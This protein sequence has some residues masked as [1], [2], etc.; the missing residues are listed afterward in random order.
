MAFHKLDFELDEEVDGTHLIVPFVD[1]RPFEDLVEQ[2]ELQ[3][4]M[5]AAGGYGGM[6]AE[7][8]D[9]DAL[10]DYFRGL[11]HSYPEARRI[12]RWRRARHG[13]RLPLGT[14]RQR[15]QVLSCGGCGEG[16]CWPG[17]VLVTAGPEQ[18]TWVDFRNPHRP[19]RDYSGFGFLFDRRQYD[20][21]LASLAG[22]VRRLQPSPRD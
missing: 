15:I 8:C 1:G 12:P 11:R 3:N 9:L 6:V 22:Q 7:G 10:P 2:Y 4:N 16:G 5:D 19:A 20:D 18:V 14:G 21:A 13:G 17:E